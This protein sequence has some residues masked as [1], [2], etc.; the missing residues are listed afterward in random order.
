M[1]SSAGQMLAEVPDG[2]ANPRPKVEPGSPICHPPGW[3]QLALERRCGSCYEMTTTPPPE[4][5]HTSILLT[6]CEKEGTAGR[7][8]ISNEM[9]TNPLVSVCIPTY[10]GEV[11]IAE[12]IRSVLAQK[13]KNFELVIVDDSSPDRTAEVVRSFV[14]PRVRL[15]CNPTNLGPEG[16]W[17]RCRQE[18]RGRYFKLL[19][20]DDI[21]HPECLRRQVAVLEAD[22]EREIALVFNARRVINAS[23]LLQAVRGYPRRG[24]GRVQRATLIRQ[25][26]RRGTNLIGEP[27]CVLMRR[28]LAERVGPFSAA[29]PYVI[30]LEYWFRLLLQGGDAWYVDE[31]LT[32]FRVSR[33]QWSVS[34]G[35]RQSKDFSRW[36]KHIS[37]CAG[38]NV[39]RLDAY[40][41]Y[42]MG[43][44]NSTLR[45]LYYCLALR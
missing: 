36:I 17:N 45:Q 16:N 33:D 38:Y 43:Q 34:I 13:F 5:H 7:A 26:L 23:G 25:C 35:S 41:G 22:V 4:F 28:E 3:S 10:R 20:Q 19:P 12:C 31:V 6:R 39:T 42:V 29:F 2:V 15:I 11:H 18:A 14:D 21:L 32:S 9:S 40:I 24:S 30:D 44:V 8:N 27:G 37:G 1:K